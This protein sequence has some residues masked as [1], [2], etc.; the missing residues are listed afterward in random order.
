M[1]RLLDALATLNQAKQSNAY[2]GTLFD[3]ELAVQN[4]AFDLMVRVCEISLKQIARG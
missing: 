1:D 4:R 3:L 2:F